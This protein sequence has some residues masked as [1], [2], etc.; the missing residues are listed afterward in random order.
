MATEPSG[1]GIVSPK[2]KD[3]ALVRRFVSQNGKGYVALDIR[4]PEGSVDP[5]A[6]TLALRVWFNDVT[7][8]FPTTDDP[9]G[10]LILDLTQSDLHREDTGKYSYDIGPQHTSQRGVLT[11]EWSYEVEGSAFTFTDH[12]QIQSAMPL[13]ETLSPAEKLVVEQV[14]WML[15]DLFDSTEGGPYL[16]E[17][18]QTHFD[19]ERI[20]QLQT[21][22][23]IRLNTT[24]FPVTHWGVGEGTTSV[25]KNYQGLMVMATYFEV[26]RH[27]IRSYVEIANKVNANITYLDRRDYMNRWQSIL[28]TEW[29]EFQKMV[30][31]AKRD[32]L[33]LGRGS[34]LVAGGIYGGSANGIFQY[35]QYVSATRAFRF[36]PAAPAVGFGSILSGGG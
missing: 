5:D 27:L 24:G 35:G 14:S 6:D 18:F 21:I 34:L 30:K 15:G 12:L 16:I 2:I 32:L 7:A 17:P 26:V 3:Q 25:P 19:Y 11:V 13:Y 9:R 20:A 33:S 31:M 28:A 22:A 4:T 1:Q 36:Y 10:E 29:P 8:Q 23:V